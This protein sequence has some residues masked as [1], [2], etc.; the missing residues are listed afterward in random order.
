MDR[1]GWVKIHRQL[2]NNPIFEKPKYLAVWMYLLLASNHQDKDIIW[3]N[4]KVTIKSGSFIGSISKIAKQFNMS[5]GTVSNILKYMVSEKMIEKQSNMSFTLF[6]ICKWSVYQ[7]DI[8]KQSENELKPNRKRIETNKNVKKDKNVKNISKD[9]GDK[10]PYGNSKLNSFMESFNKAIGYNLPMTNKARRSASNCLELFTKQNKKGEN[11]KGRDFLEDK[12]NV[13][14]SM[15]I[16]D[17]RV[18]KLNK[19]FAPGSWYKVYENV[20]MWID[21]DGTF[22]I[23]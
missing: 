3:T 4:K 12:A 10:S 9:I 19:G 14:A 8:E 21:N 7:G 17:Y 13:N 1:Q 11:K 22:P 23:K 20:R 15:F 5:T 16:R 6:S 2:L 18:A